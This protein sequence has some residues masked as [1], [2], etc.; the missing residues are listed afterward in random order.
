MLGFTA[1]LPAIWRRKAH[2]C[3]QSL[4][5]SMLPSEIL[6]HIS[7]FLPPSSAVC[8]AIC[9]RR[10]LWLLG[11]Q[12]LRCLRCVDQVPERKVFLTL[13]EKD[14]S[15]WLLCR[16]CILFHPVVQDDGPGN[17]WRYYDEPKC[18]Q[19][20]GISYITLEFRIQFQHAQLLMNNYRFGRAL[21]MY[22]DRLSY[23]FAATIGNKNIKNEVW[24]SIFMGELLVRVNSKLQ[25]PSPPDV[26][27]VR[28]WIPEICP[29]L[30]GLDHESF[31]SEMILCRPCHAGRLP[32]VECSKRRSCRKCSTWFQVKGRD[33][34]KLGTEIQIDIWKYLGHCESPFDPMWRNQIDSLCLDAPKTSTWPEDEWHGVWCS[35]ADCIRL[36]E[37]ESRV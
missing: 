17:L 7:G 1:L 13:L 23:K 37:F 34:G 30:L 6:Q 31:T 18:V 24:G 35:C 33:L 16:H 2:T 20:S 4:K 14:L 27:L 8:L 11:D 12:A 32:C 15:D 36:L 9:S 19:M 29:H 28:H 5:L 25:L 21:Q 22:L 3:K 26:S 10:V